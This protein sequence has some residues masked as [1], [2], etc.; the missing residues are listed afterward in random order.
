MESTANLA[1]T[2][3]HSNINKIRGWAKVPLSPWG[4]G[5]PMPRS[6]VNEDA[7]D[8]HTSW[9]LAAC[10]QATVIPETLAPGCGGSR[11]S[12]LV[13][14]LRPLPLVPSLP[15]PSGSFPDFTHLL[16]CVWLPHSMYYW[17]ICI[18]YVYCY[19]PLAQ[20]SKN[21]CILVGHMDDP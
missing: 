2:S 9:D 12:S 15:K 14:G 5:D 19:L 7:R 6:R 16:C 1:W 4:T 10:A 18:S 17:Y 3:R 20:I 21:C 8:K 11:D 13:L